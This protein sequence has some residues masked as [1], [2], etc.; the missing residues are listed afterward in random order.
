VTQIGGELG[1]V[2]D[3]ALIAELGLDAETEV[4]VRVEWD[5]LILEPVAPGCEPSDSS[6]EPPRR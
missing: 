6:G 4:E 2:F 1:I 5:R 3:E